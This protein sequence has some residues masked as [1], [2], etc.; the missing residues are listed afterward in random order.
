MALDGSSAAVDGVQCRSLL[1]E[2]YEDAIALGHVPLEVADVVEV[3]DVEEGDAADAE[4][5]K[6]PV[7]RACRR[8]AAD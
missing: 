4:R 2:D 8:V 5:E 6:P 7:E 1:S 3:I